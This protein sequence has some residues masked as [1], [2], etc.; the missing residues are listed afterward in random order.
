MLISFAVKNYRCFADE[1]I[2][3]FEAGSSQTVKD[4]SFATGHP[5]APRLLQSACI[6]GPNGA[7]KTTFV[8]AMGFFQWFVLASARMVQ[9]GDEIDVT[10]FL[11]DTKR[12]GQPSAFEA[13][14]IHEGNYYKYGFAVDRKRVW[15]E[16][17]FTRDAKPYSKLRKLFER[18]YI[19]QKEDYVWSISQEGENERICKSM[20]RYDA[21]FVTTA[22]QLNSNK[23]A[24]PFAA[25]FDWVDGRLRIIGDGT[26]HR[27][28]TVPSNFASI[29]VSDSKKKAQVL[30]MLQGL[31]CT[32]TDFNCTIVTRQP[33]MW[34]YHRHQNGEEVPFDFADESEG[35]KVFFN[36]AGQLIGVLDNGYTLVIDEIHNGLHPLALRKLLG[37]FHDSE[38]NKHNAQLLYTSHET[39]VMRDDFVHKDQVWFAE[40]DKG[41]KASLYALAEFKEIRNLASFQKAY[42]DGRFGAVPRLKRIV[43]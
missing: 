41:E 42:L 19:P 36:L 4:Y 34:F 12:S 5:A 37:L 40:K 24:V 33:V 29:C 21:L 11:L 43:L 15:E 2:L 7:G 9:V 6:F 18:K 20:T 1:Q 35:T 31:D 28:K 25:P 38:N 17:L 22:H 14:F 32:I 30:E 3:S 23:F 27:Y 16:W 26:L 13:C 10:P 8:N 39:S